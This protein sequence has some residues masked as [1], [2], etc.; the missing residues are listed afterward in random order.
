MSRLPVREPR[1]NARG[2]V[3]GRR[4]AS[5]PRHRSWPG[6]PTRQRSSANCTLTAPSSH[7]TRMTGPCALTAS[8][9]PL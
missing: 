8:T 1:Y 9:R 7:T 2:R 4:V 6:P 3:W 5:R